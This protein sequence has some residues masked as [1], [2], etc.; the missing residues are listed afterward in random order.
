MALFSCGAATAWGADEVPVAVMEFTGKGGVTQE[1]MDSLG[2]LLA[3]SI[4]ALGGFR[5]IGKSD[6]RAVINFDEQRQLLGCDELGCASEIGGALGV[7]WVVVGNVSQFEQLY[8][9][10]LK[11]MDVSKLRIEKGLS[12]KVEGGQA[13]LIDAL[14][15][16]VEELMMPLRESAVPASGGASPPAV[17]PAVETGTRSDTAG[18]VAVTR[19]LERP[20]SALNLWGHV[21]L[22][23]GAGVSALGFAFLGLALKEANAYDIGEVGSLAKTRTFTGLMWASF[24]AGAALMAAGLTLWLLDD[25]TSATVAATPLPGGGASVGVAGRF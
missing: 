21:T 22:W 1:Q 8:L 23:S 20:R 16:L 19:E 18:A 3:N 15:G 25:G 12:R 10:N 9:V 13:K 14:A 5:V 17:P 11:L 4:R 24:G 6:I 7:R 2:D